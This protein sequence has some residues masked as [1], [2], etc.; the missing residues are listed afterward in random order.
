MADLAGFPVLGDADRVKVLGEVDEEG[1]GVAVQAPGR[2][3]DRVQDHSPALAL[4]A[5]S[6]PPAHDGVAAGGVG[7]QSAGHAALAPCFQ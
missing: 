7:T 2:G 6:H 1:A 3:A 5:G 4:R